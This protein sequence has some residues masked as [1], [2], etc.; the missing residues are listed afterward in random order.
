MFS[1]GQKSLYG[2]QVPLIFLLLSLFPAV[3]QGCRRDSDCPNSSQYCRNLNNPFLRNT[4]W[5]KES[6]GAVC[7][8]DAMCYSGKQH[9]FLTYSTIVNQATRGVMIRK[10]D[11]IFSIHGVLP[12]WDLIFFK[13]NI[14]LP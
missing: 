7:S 10:I 5:D 8:R 11:S 1:R 2:L 6:N 14:W 3:V 13:K 4:C 12:S 9:Y